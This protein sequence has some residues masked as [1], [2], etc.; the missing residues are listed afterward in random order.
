MSEFLF[1]KRLIQSQSDRNRMRVR[2]VTEL[3]KY[4]NSF[5]GEV[6]TTSNFNSFESIIMMRNSPELLQLLRM[7]HPDDMMYLFQRI[8]GDVLESPFLHYPQK[9]VKYYS[10]M[11]E[12]IFAELLSNMD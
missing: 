4:I 3:S 9:D 8:S 6:S 2:F 12:C 11:Y 1:W 5:R 10:D 7:R